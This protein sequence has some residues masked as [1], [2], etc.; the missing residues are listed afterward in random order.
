[1]TDLTLLL[2]HDPRSVGPARAAL[3]S[4]V[5]SQ[6]SAEDVDGAAVVVSELVTNA[7]RVSTDERVLLHVTL[8]DLTLRI[9]VIDSDTAHPSVPSAA[10]VD[11]ENG[12]GLFL[13]QSLA[14]RWGTSSHTLGKCVWAEL[15]V[16]LLSL[17]DVG[18]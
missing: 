9:E 14:Q 7:Q 6:V 4:F 5:G 2:D 18:A 15:P 10:G 16:R 13:V 8:I 12:R 3:R 1:M 17:P 11:A